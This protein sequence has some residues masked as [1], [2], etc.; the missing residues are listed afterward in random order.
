MRYLS[1]TWIYTLGLFIHPFVYK[2]STDAFVT[3]PNHQILGKWYLNSQ[4]MLINGKEIHQHFEEMAAQVSAKSGHAVDPS[5]LADKFRKGF[6]GIPEGTVFEFNEDFSYRIVMPDNQVQQGFW[7]IKNA[8]TIVLNAQEEEM[9]LEI[10]SIEKDAATVAIKE[11]KNT[12]GSRYVK[13]ELIID[14]TR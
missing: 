13:M 12:G 8:L 2:L 9:Y 14:L 6:Q 5:L 4:E 3:P 10:R 7:R 1:F 11:E